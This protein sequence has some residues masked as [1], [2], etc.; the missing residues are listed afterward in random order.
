MARPGLETIS[1][2]VLAAAG[3]A[4]GFAGSAV[5][6]KR[7][8]RTESVTTILFWLTVMQ[9]VFGLICAGIDGAIA[10]PSPASWP[11]LVVIGCAGLMAH[12]CLTTALSLAP[13][14]VVIPLDFARLPVIAI[15]GMLL[16]DEPLEMAVLVGA[17]L[18]FGANYF[19]VYVERRANARAVSR[20]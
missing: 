19:N 10:L 20:G 17:L 9:S 8:T 15:V 12:F 3:A 7:L 14:T 2:G 13:A 11:W 18:I 6:T 5:L 1:P 4:V 16:Y